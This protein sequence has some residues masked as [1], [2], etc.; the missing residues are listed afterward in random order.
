[1]ATKD[2]TIPYQDLVTLVPKNLRNPVITS[3]IDNLFNRFLTA[4]ESIPLYGY[5]GRK[6]SAADDLTPK[7]P[8]P[9]V[10]RDINALVPVYSFKVGQ[11]TYSFTPQ[12]LIRKAEVLG[13]SDDLS[14]WLYS[15]GNNYA[16]PINLEKFTN[17][18]DYYWVADALPSAPTMVWNPTLAPEYYTIAS[19]LPSDL[20]KLNVRTASVPS[21]LPFVPTGSGF[22]PLTYTVTFTSS[23]QFTVQASGTLIGFAPG[24][25][26]QGPFTLQ[27]LPPTPAFP[28]PWP[29]FTDS[30]SFSVASSAAPLLTFDILRDVLLDGDGNPLGYESFT[31]GDTFTIT[32]PF[33]SS[34]F[35]VSFSGSAG[36]KGK[37]SNVDSLD[38]Y[39]TIGG[40]QVQEGDRVLIK[41]GSNNEQYIYIVS[42]GTW[43]LADDF[44]LITAAAGAKTWVQEGVNAGILFQSYVAGSGFG[45]NSL[46]AQPS[47]TNDW[48]ETNFWVK[49]TD[50]ASMNIDRAKVTQATRPIIEFFSDIQLNEYVNSVD[51][52]PTD[53]A[54]P[55][56]VLYVQEKTEFNQAPLYDLYRYD[57]HHARSVTPLFFYVEDPTADIDTALQRR[58]K[59]TTSSSADFLFDHGLRIGATHLFYKTQANGL[60]T[61]WHPGYS[62]ATVVDQQFGGTGNGTLSV[63]LT[64]VDPFTAQQIWTL[65][66]LSPTTFEVKGSKN[67]VLPS[68]YDVLVVGTPYTNNLFNATITTGGIPFVPGDTFT[69]RI[70]NFETTRYVYR[71]STE[72][73]LDLYG[74]PSQDTNGVGTWQIPRMFFGNVAASN[75]EEIPEGT[76]Y[77]HFR[78]ILM[79]Q[80]ELTNQDLAFGGSIKL[81]SEQVNLLSALLMER[82]LTPISVIDLAQREYESALNSIVDLYFKEIIRYQSSTDV[83]TTQADKNALLDYLLSIRALDN[84]VR[85]VLFDSTSP[86]LGFPATLPQLGVSP[87]VV[88]GAYFDNELGVTLMRHHDGHAS[89]LNVQTQEFLDR[90]LTPGT[91]IERSD[92]TFTPAIGSFST[93]PPANPYKGELWQYPLGTTTELRVFNVIG[94]TN[95]APTPTAVG[96]YWYNHDTN[97]LYEWDGAFWVVQANQLLPWVT[98]TPADLLNDLINEIETRL[99]NGINPNQR[100][101]FSTSDIATALTGPLASE[102]ERELATWAATNG[103]DPTAPDYVSTDAFTWNYTGSSTGS[104]APV[105]TAAIPAR[106]FNAL[107]AHHATFGVS[108]I[109]TSRPNLEPW[110]LL[111]NVTKPAGWDATYA[112]DITPDDIAAGSY[113][114]TT[115][116]RIVRYS[117]TPVTTTLSGLQTLDGVALLAGDVVLLASETSAVNNG[118]WIVSSGAWTRSSVPLVADLLVSIT[119]GTWYSGTTWWL[120][121][122]VPVVNVDPVLFS[123]VRYWKQSMWTVI[124][125][126]RPTLKLSVNVANDSLLPPY[127]SS[128]FPWASVALTNTL[129][130]DPAQSYEFGEG[131]LVETVWMRSIEFRYSLP[132]A[133]FRADPLAWIGHLWGFEWVEV[134]GILYDGFDISVPGY[135]RFRLHGDPISPVTRTTPFALT[136]ATYSG[137]IDVTITHDAY[138]SVRG[139]SWTIAAADGTIL[140]YMT[141][142]ASPVTISSNGYTLT[143]LAIEDEG[144][145]FRI[146]DSFRVTGDGTGAFTAVLNQTSYAQFHGFGQTFTN[147]LREASIDTTQGYAIK[148]YRDWNVNLGY[149][150]GGLVSTDDLRVYTDSLTLPDSSYELRFKS[151]QYAKDL[152]VQGLRVSVVQMGATSINKYGQTIVNGDASDWTFRIEGYNPRYLEITYYTFGTGGEV[153]FYALNKDHTDLPWYQPT[154]VTGTVTAQLPLTI[155]GLQNVVDVLFGYS[156]YLADQGWRFNDDGIQNIDAAT[157]R[158]RNWQLEIE[159]M[160]DRMYKGIALGDG[161]VVNPFLDRV[162]I[163]HDIGLLS[164][165]YDTALFDVTGNPGVF[166][167]L[168]VKIETDAL[169]VLRGREKSMISANVPMFSVHAQLEEY[170]HLFVFSNYVSPD[171]NEGLIYDPFSAAR[172]ATIKMNG[173]RQAASTLRPEFG[174]HYLV[175]DEVRQNLRGAA[176]KVA[177]YYDTDTVFEDT[178]STRHA[179]ALLGFSPKDYMSDLD[180]NDRSQFNFWRG[181]VQM[182]GTNSSVDAFLNNQ[183]FNDA[184]L[185]E[186][187]AYKL[188]EYGDSRTK[189]FPE[190]KLSVSDTVQQFT[191]LMFT[192]TTAPA[193]YETFTLI[194]ATDED[195]WFSIDDLDGD[196]TFEAQV[197][198]TYEKTVVNNEVVSLPFVADKLVIVGSATQINGTTLKATANGVLQVTGYGPSTP[199]FNP[200]KLFNYDQPALIEEI[201]QWHPLIGQH[202][203]T[204]LESINII[205]DVDPARYNVSTRVVGNVNYDPLRA[206]G[207]K[208]VGRVWWDTT[209]LDYLP[210][211]DQTIF[212]TVD[213]RLSR[214]GTLADYASVDVVEWVES[215]VQPSDYNAQAAIDAGDSDLD[216]YTKAAGE[217]YGKKTYQRDRIWS[218]RPIAWS[219]AG[220][221]TEAA[222]P[223]M[224]G[225]TAGN[226]RFVG[227]LA[228]LDVGLFND[229]GIGIG[230]RFGAWQADTS[231]TRPLSENIFVDAFTKHLEGATFPIVATNT[232]LSAEVTLSVTDH[233]DKVGQLQFTGSTVATQLR[234]STG[235]LVNE[236]DVATYLRVTEI[237]NTDD[238]Q[239][240]LI[241]NDRGLD[242][243]TATIPAV[244]ASQRVNFGVAK[245]ATDATY[246]DIDTPAT[247]GH[248]DILFSSP[249]AGT[250]GTGLTNDATVYTATVTVDGVAKPIS[251]VGSTAQTFSSLISQLNTDLDG[252]AVATLAGSKITITSVTTGATS[253][254]TMAAPGLFS[255]LTNYASLA[256]SVNGT[257]IMPAQYSFDVELDGVPTTVTVSGSDAQTF[258]ELISQINFQLTGAPFVLVDGDIVGYAVNTVDITD[259]TLF[260]ALPDFDQIQTAIAGT[261]AIP[262]V[263]ASPIYGATFV[264]VAGDVYTWN[265]T[266]FGLSITMKITSGGT[267]A[268]DVVMNWLV[269]ELDSLI[270]MYDAAPYEV[271]VGLIDPDSLVTDTS[272]FSNNSLDPQY[273]VNNGVGWRAW[274]TPSQQM[275]DDDSRVPN[276]VWLPYLGEYTVLNPVSINNIQSAASGA[277][278]FT[279]NEG[280]VVERYRTSWTD[281]E[282]LKNITF[283]STATVTADIEFNVGSV[284]IDHVSVYING[285][286]QLI[287]TYMLVGT[288][289]TV[290]AVT[291]GHNVTVI[292]RPYEPT[293]EDLAFDPDTA[294]DLLIQR[295][296]KI[297]Y[298]HVAIPVRDSNGNLIS[299]KYFFWVKNRTIAARKKPLS[300][301]AV[302]Q[303]LV[304]GPSQYL[305]FQHINNVAPFFYDAITISGLSYVVTKD[306]TYKLRFTRNFTLRDD[307]QE[308]D[309]KDTH[310][311]WTLI[312]PG[313]RSKIPEV[314]WS[315]MTNTACGQDTAGNTLPSPQ[316]T[317]YDSRNGTNT[318]FGFGDDQVLAPTELVTSTLLFTILNTKLV[319]NSGA[320]PIPDYMTFLDFSQ[321]NSWFSTPE[322]T[323][324]TLTTIW[325]R[326][327]V[328][329]INELFF[330]VLDDIT[331]ANYEL[332]DLFKTSRLSAYSIK[333]VNTPTIESTYE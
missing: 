246:L 33:L 124:A 204:A 229:H 65:T 141:E 151:S 220:V 298:Q 51:G 209:N 239:S 40:V 149:R 273:T 13:L 318:R 200:L 188:A 117:T 64:G 54:D 3:L 310:T 88:P 183:R 313:Q 48:Q 78:G 283:S 228:V 169:T 2:Y 309:L 210:Y 296:Y 263:P 45:W 301:K 251:I 189:I 287:G 232:G 160:I 61:I 280:T 119:A 307:P 190:L 198:G 270:K 303:Q 312:R 178:I 137:D 327:K 139:Q 23:S 43:E 135:P 212:T 218:A 330:A 27:T 247:Y 18:F 165:F 260:A 60:K 8:Q 245:S 41:D 217:V 285:V 134:D 163:E 325:N 81:W 98:F 248:K 7:V 201:P 111:G 323:R 53:A 269:T 126:A 332:T 213:E 167:T 144:Q 252:A 121:A 140:G 299:T 226:L 57:G 223:A 159:K 91:L 109:P 17:F 25:D 147:A 294:D 306:D 208:E 235:L 153:S 112:A 125:S 172:I 69:F 103:Y 142:G 302:T 56:G 10:E 28:G 19:P 244:P 308:M 16:P 14:T 168:G 164:R 254:V 68:P 304:Q 233:S 20:N 74:G 29:T 162:W 238:T 174:G 70:G 87:K 222:H 192:E 113:T 321:S 173:R 293:V 42:P 102:L 197:I 262:A 6:P 84:D 257:D 253:T 123:Q 85:T 31:A 115:T 264:A 333:V 185:D 24:E 184:K 130:P 73:L 12:D 193:G 155:T 46:G 179:L 214:W 300:V 203:P 50:L 215:S 195:R 230:T 34:T 99:Y 276:S 148:A 331:A 132:R 170:E 105:N 76:L 211:A 171:T 5:V 157:G 288:M 106:W 234:D 319:D 62:S 131:S 320:V 240:V 255:S 216:P 77:S 104:F 63:N 187:W 158:V 166:D 314:L 15:Q 58:V 194:S 108:V 156:Q 290:F 79:N 277:E 243:G 292:V 116:A 95:T 59:L 236:W 39:Q 322:N 324:N 289:L 152:W 30:V 250:D 199:K 92:G 67:E 37:I 281:W 52:L 205:A 44:N 4:D 143:G 242:G 122:T 150:A 138:T 224:L 75:G 66:A 268:T 237:D 196:T 80:L 186:F 286:A 282:E 49:G 127:V 227:D 94:D 265:F 182:K 241:R 316:R 206:W 120:S 317:A 279:L 89:P 128:S 26:L 305:T 145:P 225:S 36:V 82:D 177:H 22:Y 129:P 9:S 181:L 55:N 275:L 266:E 21:D 278:T 256:A 86:V 259:V 267:F 295:Q 154:N 47:N 291:A 272:T 146:G 118:L 202:T 110:K 1:M 161:Q 107:Q 83:V 231:A 261:P 71:D 101:Y 219:Q 326:G 38:V 221:P 297:D 90:M 97:I 284:S 93:S 114:N 258:G 175:G 176:D 72:K 96:D 133:L 100:T 180:L 207:A 136:T 274:N 328:T 315:K 311:E 249:T 11:D 32:A 35:S 191:K 271:V 329:Q